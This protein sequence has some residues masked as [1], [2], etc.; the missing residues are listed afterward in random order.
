[1]PSRQAQKIWTSELIE[2]LKNPLRALTI[3]AD[4][5]GSSEESMKIICDLLVRLEKRIAEVSIH[6]GSWIDQIQ[7]DKQVI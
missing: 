7:K 4:L 5:S 6:A 3:S 2:R 1:V